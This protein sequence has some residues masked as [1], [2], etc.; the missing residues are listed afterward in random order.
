MAVYMELHSNDKD[1]TLE[2]WISVMV[3]K[4]EEKAKSTFFFWKALL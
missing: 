4:A 3:D 1:L 2:E